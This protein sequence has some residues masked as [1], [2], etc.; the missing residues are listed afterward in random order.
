MVKK[1]EETLKPLLN[2]ILSFG[3]AIC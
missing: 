2:L 3:K 1:K